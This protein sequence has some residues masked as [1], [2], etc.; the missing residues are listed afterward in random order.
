MDRLQS[1]GHND[2]AGLGEEL[3]ELGPWLHNLHLPGGVQTAPNHPRGDFPAQMWEQL[4]G[5]LPEDLGGW[6]ALDIGCN[7][8][9]Y[10]FELARRGAEVVGIDMDPHYLRQ[11]HWACDKLGMADRVTFRQMQLY[12][13][14]RSS[15]SYD[16][17]LFWGCS[18]N[19]ATRC[20]RWTL[21]PSAPI[22]CSPFS[23]WPSAMNTS[24][25]SPRT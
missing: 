24:L 21:S 1:R 12:E 20:W 18:A 19:C 15:E 11:A 8:G 25:R 22:A 2:A 5:G 3:L 10:S 14:A 13:L 17:V 23:R 7:A 4:R 6:R 16:L 9:F